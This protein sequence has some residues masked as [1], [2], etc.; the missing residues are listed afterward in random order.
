MS[1]SGRNRDRSYQLV[2][3]EIHICTEDWFPVNSSLAFDLNHPLALGCDL[4]PHTVRQY[5]CKS[6]SP[7]ILK[8]K[9]V[10]GLGRILSR[11][12]DAHPLYRGAVP[13]EQYN[14]IGVFCLLLTTASGSLS[15]KAFHMI[16]M[17]SIDSDSI[18]TMLDGLSGPL[19]GLTMVGGI[20]NP[21]ILSRLPFLREGSKSPS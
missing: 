8:R 19:P 14:S 2:G 11:V 4:N 21:S 15:R 10:N 16:G 6:P 20:D 13:G 18:T 7:I 5:V 1:R 12:L 17:S 3:V 9:S